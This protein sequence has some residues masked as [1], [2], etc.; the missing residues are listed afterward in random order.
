MIKVF[1]A[2]VLIEKEKL[3]SGGM[4]LTMQTE[5]DGQNNSGVIKGIGSWWMRFFGLKEGQTIYFRKHFITNAGQPEE[6]VF[7]YFED[8]LA[9][10]KQKNGY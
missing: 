9:I 1:G 2:R 5:H 4:K 3:D 7:V 10:N 8:I 6:L